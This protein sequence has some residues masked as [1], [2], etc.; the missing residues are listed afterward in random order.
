MSSRH[1]MNRADLSYVRVETYS[2]YTYNILPVPFRQLA[3][4]IRESSYMT[5]RWPRCNVIYVPTET[6]SLFAYKESL[7]AYSARRFVSL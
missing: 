5:Q 7:A 4:T 1:R 6:W 2:P 3:T